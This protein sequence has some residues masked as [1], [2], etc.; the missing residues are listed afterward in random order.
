MKYIF[1]I[2]FSLLITISDAQ[3]GAIPPVI[4]A[5]NTLDDISRGG[6]GP[7][8]FLYGLPVQPGSLVGD[9][10]L[11]NKWNKSRVLLYA[12]DKL[13]EGVLSRFDL[14]NQ[15]LEIKV[16][17]AIKILEINRIK[18]LVWFDS[19]TN[20]PSYYVNAQDY[21]FHET[22]LTGLL[23]VVVDGRLPLL[24]FTVI[25]I[26]KADYNVALDVGSKDD[27]VLHKEIL[28]FSLEN[29]LHEIKS[30]KSL[31]TVFKDS[32]SKVEEF[33]RINKLSFSKEKDIKRIFEFYN[34]F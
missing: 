2:Y 13:L 22:K 16:D 5:Q 8:T 17:N 11:D 1:I 10:Y 33:V 24:K 19:E 18:S 28:F 12:G 34:S 9:F 6:V 23:E 7:N 15:H 21:I 27:K 3:N 31:A 32:Q 25:T 20:Q 26:K 29:N 30:K 14:K 4:R